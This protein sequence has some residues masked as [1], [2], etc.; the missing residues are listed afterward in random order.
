MDE[1]FN[2][3][4][5]VTSDGSVILLGMMV[6]TNDWSV[7]KVVGDATVVCCSTGE[8]KVFL[9][10]PCPKGQFKVGATWFSDHLHN[11]ELNYPHTA[12]RHDHWF[13]VEVDGARIGIF[14]GE[15]LMKMGGQ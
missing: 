11:N 6:R 7:G 4:E 2:P 13:H 10:G 3:H 9:D 5:N 12:C 1:I 8:H 14:N 15:R